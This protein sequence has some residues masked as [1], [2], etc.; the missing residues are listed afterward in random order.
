MCPDE[1]FLCLIGRDVVPIAQRKAQPKTRAPPPE[2]RSTLRDMATG[3]DARN[4]QRLITAI[5][6]ASGQHPR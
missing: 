6:H 3:L 1:P 4:V 5:S 2:P